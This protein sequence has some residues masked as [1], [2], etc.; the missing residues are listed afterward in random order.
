M[1]QY[2]EPKIHICRFC[3]QG[4]LNGRQL[5][6]HMRRHL[7]L[8]AACKQ[9]NHQENGN[10]EMGFDQIVKKIEDKKQ[11]IQENGDVMVKKSQRIVG[12]DQDF[13][14]GNLGNGETEMGFDFLDDQDNDDDQMIKKIEGGKQSI[15]ENDD[16]M[17]KKSQQIVGV[18]QDFDKGKLGNN[19]VYVLREN[20][21][22]TWRVSNDNKILSKDYVCKKRC[23]SR[24]ELVKECVCDKCGKSFGSM[25]AL[26]GH[27][28]CHSVKKSRP[29]DQDDDV[30]DEVANPVKKKRSCTRYKSPKPSNHCD[31]L[32]S[33]CDEVEYGAV[34]L[35]MLSRGVRD[36]DEVK[37]VIS[38]Q[39]SN[40]EFEVSVDGLMSNKSKMG[41]KK[42]LVFETGSGQV[43]MSRV[44]LTK[45]RSWDQEFRGMDV[46]DFEISFELER[47]SKGHNCPICLK[48]FGS[49]RALGR[50]KRVH[51]S[52]IPDVHTL[53]NPDF[54]FLREVST[55]V[56]WGA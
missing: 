38:Q 50:H 26:Y 45:P 31:S 12:V 9:K 43:D 54:E 16:V 51:N 19:N 14:K 13:G 42:D 27:M 4:F 20:P 55:M 15:Q 56:L 39:A 23:D 2:Q 3:K 22:K 25:K 17:V 8:I 6:G 36:L 18:D 35:M 44:G 48:E 33:C 24:K 46:T 30:D 49:G 47:R 34:C 10:G 40:V 1:K 5:G 7:A 21:K 52:H 32:S 41:F 29:L 28:R 37:M 11:S 53:V